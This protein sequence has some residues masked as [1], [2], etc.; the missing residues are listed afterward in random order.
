MYQFPTRT[1][2]LHC[3][4]ADKTEICLKMLDENDYIGVIVHDVDAVC[5]TM[6]CLFH[7]SNYDHVRLLICRLNIISFCDIDIV[8]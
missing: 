6:G 4:I 5:P 8:I 7:L 1:G 2:I 3:K